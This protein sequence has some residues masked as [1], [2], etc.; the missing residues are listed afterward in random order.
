MKRR[1]KAQ[2]PSREGESNKPVQRFGCSSFIVVYLTRPNCFARGNDND[3]IL[4]SVPL[5][6]AIQLVLPSKLAETPSS[7]VVL[8]MM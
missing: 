2:F 8:G 6:Y 4:V 1:I 3:R 5:S 7:P